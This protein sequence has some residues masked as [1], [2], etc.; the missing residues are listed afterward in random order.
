MCGVSLRRRP[1]LQDEVMPGAEISPCWPPVTVLQVLGSGI[2]SAVKTT[3]CRAASASHASACPTLIWNPWT[4]R[5]TS[6]QVSP[7]EKNSVSSLSA[8]EVISQPLKGAIPYRCPQQKLWW[9]P[10]TDST[11]PLPLITQPDSL[12]PQKRAQNLLLFQLGLGKARCFVL[13]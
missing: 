11:K 7:K 12:Q 8:R 6:G 3:I 13:S 4:T 5:G 9:T 1:G 2:G 10:T